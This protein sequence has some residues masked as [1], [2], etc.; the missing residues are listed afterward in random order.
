MGNLKDL[1]LEKQDE[2]SNKRLAK[3]LGITYD[4]LN[5]LD[6]EINQEESEDGLIYHYIISFAVNDPVEILKKIIDIDE[7][8]EVWITSSEFDNLMS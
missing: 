8:N 2:E 6:F 7:N 4:E 3:I 5:E 1:I